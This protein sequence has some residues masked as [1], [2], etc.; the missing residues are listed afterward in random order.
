MISP[1]KLNEIATENHWYR[2]RKSMISPHEINDIATENQWNRHRK[3]MISRRHLKSLISPKKLND[4]ILVLIWSWFTNLH[5]HIT[6]T[7]GEHVAMLL[8]IWSAC[9]YQRQWAFGLCV[10]SL[11]RDRQ[12]A[13]HPFTERAPSSHYRS[14]PKLAP[15]PIRYFSGFT[16]LKQGRIH[17]YPSR[18]RV[19]RSVMK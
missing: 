12:F 1:Q 18:V 2:H 6:V 9:S 10:F 13:L 7:M 14:C 17:G 3:S 4:S 5:P 15:L 11:S 8:K 19:G 16:D